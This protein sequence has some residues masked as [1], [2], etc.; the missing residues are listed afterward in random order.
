[1]ALAADLFQC[2]V[3][4]TGQVTC[5]RHQCMRPCAEVV[6]GDAAGHAVGAQQLGHAAAQ[7]LALGVGGQFAGV[8][9]P[10]RDFARG[11]QGR[12]QQ[13]ID[14]AH[15]QHDAGRFGAD[16]LE[17]LRQQGEFGVVRQ[18]DAEH[19][20]AGGRVE[21]GGAADRGGDGIQR[22]RQQGEDFMCSR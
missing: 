10:H 7:H 4:E 6:E 18:A 2:F 3:D 11:Q 1:M 15:H 19:R 12:H 17:Q 14:P 20:V 21:L 13:V 16:A 8:A 9:H 5:E 22:R